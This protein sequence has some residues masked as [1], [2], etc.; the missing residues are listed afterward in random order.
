MRL[1]EWLLLLVAAIVLPL[2]FQAIFARKSGRVRPR[3]RHA[4]RFLTARL[5]SDRKPGGHDADDPS[6]GSDA[7]HGNSPLHGKESS[8]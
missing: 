6:A 8:A 1:F 7:H 5:A 2:T 3:S 4:E